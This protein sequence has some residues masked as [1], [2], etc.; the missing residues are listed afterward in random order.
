MARRFEFLFEFLHFS[1]CQG[2]KSGIDG[3][4][5][6]VQGFSGGRAAGRPM[7]SGPPFLLGWLVF[8]SRHAL[9]G[10]ERRDANM[11]CGGSQQG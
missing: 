11:V 6:R 7:M 4:A 1:L 10:K 5:K 8:S 3:M 2:G 9:R